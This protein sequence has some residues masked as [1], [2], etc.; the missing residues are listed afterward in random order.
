MSS[1][2]FEGM[3]LQVLESLFQIWGIGRIKSQ[4]CR[5]LVPMAEFQFA[6]LSQH[7]NEHEDG[8]LRQSLCFSA[9]DRRQ[10]PAPA[11]ERDDDEVP[12]TEA[13]SCAQTVLPH[14]QAQT[15]PLVIRSRLFRTLGA[16]QQYIFSI[17]FPFFFFVQLYVDFSFFS[18]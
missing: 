13:G 3:H 12:G 16:H 1:R 14:R 18:V 9:G 7:G 17:A 15:E 4:T 6:N 10:R 8:E 5:L 11:E 2:T